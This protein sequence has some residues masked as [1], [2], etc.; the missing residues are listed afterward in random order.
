MMTFGWHHSEILKFLHFLVSFPQTLKKL[1]CCILSQGQ[2]EQC[3]SCHVI[4]DEKVVVTI[5]V[6]S[7]LGCT[8]H[9]PDVSGVS[10][11]L[12]V[13]RKHVKYTVNH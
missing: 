2:E 13:P 10:I 8:Q 6:H 1:G 9:I 3:T 11:V 12:I 5:I 4:G 7:G